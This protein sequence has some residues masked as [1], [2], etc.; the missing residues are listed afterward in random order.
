V[1]L[2][3]PVAEPPPP[4]AQ[5]RRIGALTHTAREMP[6]SQVVYLESGSAAPRPAIRP[7]EPAA[8]IQFGAGSARLSASDRDT[9]ARIAALAK[10]ANRPVKIVGHAGRPNGGE[11]A[12]QEVAE[13][14]L[15]L[16]RA[17]AVATEMMRNG[18]PAEQMTVQAVGDAEPLVIAGS[19]AAE[20]ANRRAEVFID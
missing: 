5:P 6:R 20:A 7:G 3:P 11:G 18:V 14:T 9:L 1:Q 13:F 16:N 12:R 4:P 15:S 10:V 19:A 2:R 17:N 8:T